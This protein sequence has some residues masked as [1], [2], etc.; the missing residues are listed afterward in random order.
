MAFDYQSVQPLAEDGLAIS[1]TGGVIQNTGSGRENLLLVRDGTDGVI[2]TVETVISTNNGNGRLVDGII[3]IREVPY[4]AVYLLPSFGSLTTIDLIPEF[5]WGTATPAPIC[6]M[7]SVS[8]GVVSLSSILKYR[9]SVTPH[10]LLT[11][12]FVI[13]NPGA[14]TMRFK[15]IGATTNTNSSIGIRV[16]ACMSPIGFFDTIK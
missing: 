8:T 1:P 2:E 16:G 13:P 12:W 3:R 9:M 10:E 5:G 7:D 14:T 4:I 11:F 6:F 15:I